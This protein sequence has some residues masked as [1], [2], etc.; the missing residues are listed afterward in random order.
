MQTFLPYPSFQ[1]ST[2]SDDLPYVWPENKNFDLEGL[3]KTKISV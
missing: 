3:T 1:K 2:E